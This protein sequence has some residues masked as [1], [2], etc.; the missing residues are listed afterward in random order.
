MAGDYI[1]MPLVNL[2][3]NK[4]ALEQEEVRAAKMRNR[5]TQMQLDAQS[6]ETQQNFQQSS[7]NLM[8]GLFSPQ[9]GQPQPGNTQQGGNSQ[10]VSQAP[11]A[12]QKVPQQALQ[13]PQA[14][15]NGQNMGLNGLTLGQRAPNGV[16]QPSG[17]VPSQQG[18]NGP[19]ADQAGTPDE[20][21]MQDDMQGKIEKAKS[22][23]IGSKKLDSMYS[24]FMQASKNNDTATIDKLG[25]FLNKDKNIS[26][27]SDLGDIKFGTGV[28]SVTGNSTLD[29]TAKWPKKSLD[30]L[31]NFKNGA[32]LK[33]LPDGA[34]VQIKIDPVNKVITGI[35]SAPK[36]TLDITKLSPDSRLKALALKEDLGRMPTAKELEEGLSE[37]RQEKKSNLTGENGVVAKG[38]EEVLG[39]KPTNQEIAD[40]LLKRATAKSAAAGE[41]RYGTFAKYGPMEVIDTEDN[42]KLKTISKKEWADSQSKN[43]NKYVESKSYEKVAKPTAILADMQT[44]IDRF[45]TDLGAMK[46]DFS[47]SFLAKMSYLMRSTNPQSAVS[48]FMDSSA[49]KMLSP[50]EQQYAVDLNQIAENAMAMRSVLGAGQGSEDLRRAIGNTVPNPRTPSKAYAIKQLEAYENQVQRLGRGL[51]GVGLRSTEQVAKTLGAGTGDTRKNK[52]KEKLTPD[53]WKTWVGPKGERVIKSVVG[54]SGKR[55]YQYA[56]GSVNYGE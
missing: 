17:A 53:N 28:D 42:N 20:S 29:I 18:L 49:A 21:D 13:S 33:R 37:E 47:P 24:I 15:V 14:P 43:P 1:S 22:A 55:V 3:P 51:P 48:N 50:D 12:Q 41:A 6:P 2:D 27:F 52:G 54:P 5:I 45:K 25:D 36:D 4:V 16:T 40:A 26:D 19:V 39:R 44:T 11:L 32:L 7:S 46:G 38:L 30:G 10:L 23:I 8:Q 9:Q 31:S 35:D 56:D 34:R